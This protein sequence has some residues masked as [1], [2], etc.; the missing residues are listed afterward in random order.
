MYEYSRRGYKC[1]H[2]PVGPGDEVGGQGRQSV[3]VCLPVRTQYNTGNVT[4]NVR[5]TRPLDDVFTDKCLSYIIF[6]FF[7]AWLL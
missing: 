4:Y 2:I 1:I 3:W 6:G 5:L 7:R